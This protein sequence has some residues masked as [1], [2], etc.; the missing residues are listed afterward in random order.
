MQ[1]FRGGSHQVDFSQGRP[2]FSGDAELTSIANLDAPSAD[3]V[4]VVTFAAGARTHWHEHEAGQ[5][6]VVVRGCGVVTVAGQEPVP[7]SEGDVVIAEAGEV[8]WHG[9]GPSSDFAHLAISRGTTTWHGLA[10]GP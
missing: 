7:L 1:V 6:L 9:A 8:H 4:S 5:V 2:T 10:E 3:S